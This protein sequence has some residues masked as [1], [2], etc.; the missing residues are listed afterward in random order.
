M[1]SQSLVQDCSIQSHL[2]CAHIK[3]MIANYNLIKGGE[4]RCITVCFICLLRVGLGGQSF[5]I[6]YLTA[7]ALDQGLGLEDSM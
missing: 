4:I 3:P 7:T 2:T 1:S 5:V 6:Y